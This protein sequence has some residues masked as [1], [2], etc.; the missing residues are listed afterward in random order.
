VSRLAAIRGGRLVRAKISGGT[1]QPCGIFLVS[2]KQDTFRYFI[3][4]L[5][6]LGAV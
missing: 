2:T 6:K 3:P 5:R 1:D 4:I